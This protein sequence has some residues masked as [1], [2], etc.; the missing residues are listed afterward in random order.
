[1]STSSTPSSVSDVHG[2]RL[3][4]GQAGKFRVAEEVAA[5]AGQ[6]L[7]AENLGKAK[8]G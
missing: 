1:L 7:T 8:T 5:D 4:D 2:N 3:L 6:H